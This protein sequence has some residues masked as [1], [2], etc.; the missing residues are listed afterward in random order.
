MVWSYLVYGL[1]TVVGVV[2][3]SVAARW[4]LG[5]GN[6]MHDLFD[7]YCHWCRNRAVCSAVVTRDGRGKRRVFLLC[8]LCRRLWGFS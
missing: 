7:T 2:L 8:D 6:E 3:G 5:E 4:F 1:L